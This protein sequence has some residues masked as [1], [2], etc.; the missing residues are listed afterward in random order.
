MNRK[1]QKYIEEIFKYC[2][3]DSIL[4]INAEGYLQRA[5]CPFGVLVIRR[6]HQL[7]KDDI[8]ACMAVKIG[9]GLI[10]VYIIDG[11]G[12]Y[13]YNFKILS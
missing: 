8:H 10:D 6:V 5:Q 12:F 2:K 4:Y 1:E 9:H 13:H 11:K 3:T 7:K